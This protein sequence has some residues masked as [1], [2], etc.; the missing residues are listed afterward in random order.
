MARRTRSTRP[1]TTAERVRLEDVKFEFMKHNTADFYVIA[2]Y[3]DSDISQTWTKPFVLRSM[4][5]MTDPT[6]TLFKVSPFISRFRLRLTIA[7]HIKIRLAEGLEY[8][9]REILLTF[10]AWSST[11]RRTDAAVSVKDERSRYQRASFYPSVDKISWCSVM[12]IIPCF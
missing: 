4:W 1:N 11:R 8:T 6:S 9:T 10:W 3:P 5:T 7:G 2:T 12:F